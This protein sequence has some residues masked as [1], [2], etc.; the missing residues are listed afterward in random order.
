MRF[1]SVSLA[2]ACVVVVDH[3][4]VEHNVLPDDIKAVKVNTSMRKIETTNE[5]GTPATFGGPPDIWP[6]CAE[7]VQVPHGKNNPNPKEYAPAEISCEITLR[8]GGNI[9]TR[10][11]K[12]DLYKAIAELASKKGSAAGKA[13]TA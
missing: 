10:G 2:L 11:K 13:A 1:I 12:G 8:S 3:A 9:R 7:N 4:G 6:P 5:D